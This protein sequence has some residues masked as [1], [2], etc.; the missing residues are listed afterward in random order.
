MSKF[1]GKTAVV[2][3]ASRGIGE[4]CIRR[5]DAEGAR[6]ALVARGTD[7]MEK[8]AAELRHDPVVI[9]ANLAKEEEVE[10]AAAQALD[11]LGGVDIL[12]N[13]AGMVWAEPAEVLTAKRM[14]L[15]L[16]LNLR[17]VMLFVSTLG[18]SLLE[19]RGSVVN[20]SSV[21][22]CYYMEDQAVYAATKG[23]LNSY[24]RNVAVAW[25]SRG[26]RVNAV[27]PG[28]VETD[29]WRPKFDAAGE[30]DVIASWKAR[31]PMDRWASPDEVASVVSFL[32][33]D[34]ASY[35]T[36]QTLYVDGGLVSA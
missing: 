21:T 5:L 16:S 2:T 27:A 13:N 6:V 30:D 26:V 34:D 4:A 14:D 36:G 9:T 23:G 25:A 1:A 7:A 20:I 10:G 33:S 8:I 18:P 11:R 17:N 28:L 15:Q 19:R 24:T 29:I 32:A 22:A 35:V 3:G 12:V 31:I